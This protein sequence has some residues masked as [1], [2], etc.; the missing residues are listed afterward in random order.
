MLSRQGNLAMNT[1]CGF[2]GQMQRSHRGFTLIELL[3]VIAIVAILAGML[4]P[5]VNLVR[6]A[7]R[8]TVCKS[9]LRQM[10]F[11]L[12][13]YADEAEGLYPPS[14]IY[15]MAS[16]L[17]GS[18]W[19]TNLLD[20]GGY[21]EVNWAAPNSIGSG[22]ITN[23]IFRCPEVATSSLYWGGGLGVMENN[24]H[25]FAYPGLGLYNGSIL[26]TQIPRPSQTALAGDVERNDNPGR[27]GVYLS[28]WSM[29]C[30]A[31]WNWSL[32]TTPMRGAR[33]HG[34]QGMMNLVWMDGHVEARSWTSVSA[35]QDDM[36]H[37]N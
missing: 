18:N 11:A 26:R 15:A 31:D 33:R 22:S 23:G 10:G 7:A 20:R 35:N 27:P 37:H 36:W 6:N 19:W 8:G 17:T 14:N 5:A 4:L 29:K 9:N 28:S 2:A 25:G 12:N 1:Q 24:A 16:G 21:I 3:V 34:S 13:T 30:P 32:A